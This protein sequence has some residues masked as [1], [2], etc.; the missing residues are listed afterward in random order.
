MM[1]GVREDACRWGASDLREVA[2]IS[3]LCTLGGPP[4]H[5]SSLMTYREEVA[6]KQSEGM[7]Y[8]EKAL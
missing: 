2:M 7:K 5:H 6:I 3:M 4:H 8:G 1:T